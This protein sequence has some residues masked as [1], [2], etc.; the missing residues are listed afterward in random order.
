MQA[1]EHWDKAVRLEASRNKMNEKDDYEMMVWC[2]IHAGAH[3]VNS[4]MHKVGFS[5]PDRDYIHSDKL[6]EGVKVPDVVM[7]MLP[8]LHSIELLGPRFVRGGELIDAQNMKFCL[9]EYAK[10][11]SIADKI[12]NH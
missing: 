3:L 6:E 5:Q 1:K 9:T 8:V 4:V 7:E 12:V 2:T 11:K 10:L